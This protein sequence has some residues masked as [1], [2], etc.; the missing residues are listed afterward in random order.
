MYCDWPLAGKVW[1][2]SDMVKYRVVSFKKDQ[3]AALYFIM[4]D[5]VHSQPKYSTAW[6]MPEMRPN[7]LTFSESSSKCDH[8]Q[9]RCKFLFAG[10]NSIKVDIDHL[11]HE[12][13]CHGG[14]SDNSN[15]CI[16][17]CYQHTVQIQNVLCKLYTSS[18]WKNK[19]GGHMIRHFIT[20]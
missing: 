14:L 4:S 13:S 3:I 2:M 19:Q 1:T 6:H 17:I 12:L 9:A 7:G 10:G 5:I 20:L 8:C 11:M 18:A 16:M 15:N